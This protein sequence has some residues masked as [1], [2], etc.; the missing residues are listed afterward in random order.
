MAIPHCNL[1]QQDSKVPN[2]YS[3]QGKSFVFCNFTHNRL[4]KR[5]ISVPPMP[6]KKNYGMKLGHFKAVV[7]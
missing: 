7:M 3:E 2:N 6:R 5:S 4:N 1:T